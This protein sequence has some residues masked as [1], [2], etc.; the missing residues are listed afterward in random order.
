MKNNLLWSVAATAVSVVSAAHFD[1]TVGKGG[2]L[3]FVPDQFAAAVGDTVTYH[4]YAKVCCACPMSH[5]SRRLMFA[6]EPLG[7]A[8][9]VREAV[10]AFG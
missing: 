8:V 9:F 5:C 10:P 6:T 3:Q 1:V 4:Y 7:G 2:Q